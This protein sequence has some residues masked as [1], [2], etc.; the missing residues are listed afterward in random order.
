MLPI[1][2][3]NSCRRGSAPVTWILIAINV[4]IY[5]F[6]QRFGSDAARTLALAA[7]PA[8]IASGQGLVKILT[9]QF[10]HS[11]LA[12]LAGNMLFLGIFG[13]NVE[14][15]IGKARY[16][17]LYLFSGTMGIL[18]HIAGALFAGGPAAASPLVGASAAISGVLASYLVLFP[19]NRVIV[20]LFNFIPTA[21]SAW[22]VIGF[23]FVFQILGGLRGLGS[24]NVA[25]LAHIGGFAASWIWSR[26]YRKREIIRLER[27]KKERASR[28]EAGEIRWWIV[29]DDE[30]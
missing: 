2:D 7:I 6:Y 19:G 23:W 16:L 12:H 14:C 28:G 24:T 27:E 10:A 18:S 22:I 15:R 4:A 21:L 8:E 11:G 13:D 29:D 5:V 20:L 9:S 25:Y 30:E 3:E 17:G 1:G 26:S